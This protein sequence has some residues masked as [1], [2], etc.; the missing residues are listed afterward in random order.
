[1]LKISDSIDIKSKAVELNCNEPTSLALIPNNF[2]YVLEKDQLIYSV[3]APTIRSLWLQNGIQET[4]IEK[5]GDKFLLKEQ[6]AFD[7]I[8]P[9]IFISGLLI[10]Q[11]PELIDVALGVISNYLADYF[12]GI[13][14]QVQ[15]VKM[16]IIEENKSGRYRKIEYEGSPEGLKDL[17]RIIKETFN[18]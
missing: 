1:M 12:K 8:S 18:E 14:K 17:P 5:T 7:W 13:P 4:R 11:N 16:K 9:I 3:E 6:N 10:S 15:N 2:E